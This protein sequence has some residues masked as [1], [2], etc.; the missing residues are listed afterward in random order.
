[1]R[2]NASLLIFY[3]IICSQ[4]FLNFLSSFHTSS[5]NVFILS[6]MYSFRREEYL[7]QLA[8]DALWSDPMDTA[9]IEI[10]VRGTY[11]LHLGWGQEELG[12]G[13]NKIS[14][15]FQKS[16]FLTTIC[17]FIVLI[18]LLSFSLPLL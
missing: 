11:V 2:S 7:K 3:H 10:N 13:K 4:K 12:S 15:Y 9:G 16:F 8:R 5:C 14:Y 1:M 18:F 6:R 17:Y